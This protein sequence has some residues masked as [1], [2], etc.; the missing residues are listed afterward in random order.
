MTRTAA[1]AALVLAAPAA[2]AAGQPGRERT[3]AFIAAFERVRTADGKLDPAQKA[4]NDKAFADLD[5]FFDFAALTGKVIEPQ[6]DKLKPDELA[7]FRTKFRELL[8]LTAY[9]NSAAFFP[10]A[11]VTYLPEKKKGELV[12]VPVKLRVEAEDLDMAVEFHWVPGPSGMRVADVLFDG[13]SL[14][15]D[16]QNQI[17]RVI[18]KNGVAGLF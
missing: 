15:K 2:H 6:A 18:A 11:K 10:R 7:M 8:R 13:D 5:A 12:A 14:V 16:Y 4:A 17:A 1:L 3:E 9:P